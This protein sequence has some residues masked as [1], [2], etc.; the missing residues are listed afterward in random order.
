MPK[1]NVAKDA[2]DTATTGSGESPPDESIPPNR[3]KIQFIYQEGADGASSAASRKIA[4]SYA[5]RES[6]ARVRRERLIN[7][8]KSEGR[9]PI[10][11]HA[12]AEFA[13]RAREDKV[14]AAVALRRGSGGFVQLPSPIT[15]LSAAPTDPFASTARPITILEHY[16]LDHCESAATRATQVR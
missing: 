1:K 14:T 13:S 6:H 3:P 4:R 5:A 2:P 10:D 9:A 11:S 8:Q 16:L 7:S 15:L 12:T